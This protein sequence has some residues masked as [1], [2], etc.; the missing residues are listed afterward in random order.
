[1]HDRNAMPSPWLLAAVALGALLAVVAAKAVV[2]RAVGRPSWRPWI[3][4]ALAAALLLAALLLL[5]R[6]AP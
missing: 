5:G 3:M 2:P 4:A 6:D 1:M